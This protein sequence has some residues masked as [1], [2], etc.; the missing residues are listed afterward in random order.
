MLG[1]LLGGAKSEA[2]RHRLGA[3]V[4]AKE[5]RWFA[6][7]IAKMVAIVERLEES[8]AEE[9]EKVERMTTRFEEVS[10]SVFG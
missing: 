9:R 4:L 10:G 8:L 2:N 5:R 3:I 6:E 1:E 7:K